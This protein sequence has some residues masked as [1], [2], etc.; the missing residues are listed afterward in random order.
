MTLASLALFTTLGQ[1]Q[2]SVDGD[3]YL[4]LVK[5][6][7]VVYS[8]SDTLAVLDG[9]L[10]VKSGATFLPTIS[11]SGS[12]DALTIDLEGNVHA[13]SSSSILGKLVLAVFPDSAGL[14]PKDGF[15]TASERPKLVQPGEE[16]YGV[17]RFVG[18]GETAGSTTKQVVNTISPKSTPKVQPPTK[19]AAPTN[20]ILIEVSPR[21]VVEGDRFTFGDVAELTGEANFVNKIRDL[22]LGD[23]P[24][25]GVERKI[26]LL[27]IEAK[28]H[29]AQIDLHKVK[30]NLPSTVVVV[31]ASQVVTEEEFL[32]SAVTA[33]ESKFGKYGSL[34]NSKPMADMHLPKGEK[35][36]VT[37]EI[38]P[39][40]NGY[41]VNVSAYVDKQLIN[42]RIMVLERSGVPD[43]VKVG[44]L[45][46]I[47][48][49]AENIFIET[50]GKVT[51][52]GKPGELVEVTTND[53]KKM[54]GTVIRSGVVEVK[55]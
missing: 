48:V 54:T 21:T 27:R 8:K 47:R 9:K 1:N 18:G 38:T 25:I 2:I 37:D 29:A 22:V 33:I 41:R 39:V 20:G 34:S 55:P 15:F 28:L 53:G 32:N 6:G 46:T 11:F 13:K 42:R 43:A 49:V 10:G 52:V 7:R 14:S 16:T 44:D 5:D 3:G 12:V 31:R 4:R 19:S 45:V 24:A 26:D 17:I 51:R 40:Q 35:K 50:S 36:L 23:T 30:I